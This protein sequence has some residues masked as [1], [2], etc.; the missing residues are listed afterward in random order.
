LILIVFPCIT[1]LPL[2]HPSIDSDRAVSA[3]DDF[4]F[5]EVSSPAPRKGF[6]KKYEDELLSPNLIHASSE[7]LLDGLSDSEFSRHTSSQNSNSLS[8]F[9]LFNR[10]E[11]AKTSYAPMSP[12]LGIA[13][14]HDKFPS[15]P[16][17]DAILNAVQIVT[18]MPPPPRSPNPSYSSNNYNEFEYQYP[19]NENPS[20]KKKQSKKKDK[21]ANSSKTPNQVGT[22]SVRIDTD[23][24]NQTPNSNVIKP[25]TCNCKRSRC[26]KLYCDCFRFRKYCASCNCND[27]ANIPSEEETRQ[28]AIAQITERNPEAFKPKLVKPVENSGGRE[29]LQGCHCKKSFCLKKYCECY[30]AHVPCSD[31]C[32][33]QECKNTPDSDVNYTFVPSSI[34]FAYNEE[35]LENDQ[36]T[37][38]LNL[39]R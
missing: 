7:F 28:L 34:T 33:C 12:K 1:L 3:V 29:H 16:G 23:S 8:G 20:S 11:N 27:C 26:L 15:S 36:L 5:S 9:P 18:R 38:S 21:E 25:V 32:R 19:S 24:T 35:N 30:T 39:N 4:S 37:P 13:E 22:P 10:D 14:R 2:P 6:K 17:L 31:K